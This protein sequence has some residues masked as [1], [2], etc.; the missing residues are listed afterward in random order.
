MSDDPSARLPN[1]LREWQAERRAIAVAAHEQDAI[2]RAAWAEA[3]PERK[4]LQ[5][6]ANGAKRRAAELLRVPPWAD[7]TAI[8]AIYRAARE[9]TRQ[10]GIAHH[11]DHDYP[12]QGEYVSGL[13]VAANLRILTAEENTR[14]SNRFVP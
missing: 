7:Q 13:H 1:G 9:L 10:T 2:A 12:L 5:N 8:A 14:K 4:R 6:T 11:V 3:R